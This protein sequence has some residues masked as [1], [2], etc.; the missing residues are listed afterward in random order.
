MQSKVTA[1]SDLIV[2]TQVLIW[3]NLSF[4]EELMLELEMSVLSFFL[5]VLFFIYTCQFCEVKLKLG[6][7]R[8]LLSW[9]SGNN[10]D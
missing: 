3:W 7:S 2:F 4:N 1:L 8:E 9:L 10:S 5:L 6:K